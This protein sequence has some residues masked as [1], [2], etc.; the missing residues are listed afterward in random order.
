MDEKGFLFLAKQEVKRQVG[1]EV[2]GVMENLKGELNK[3]LGSFREQK[4]LEKDRNLSEPNVEED[5][6]IEGKSDIDFLTGIWSEENQRRSVKAFILLREKLFKKEIEDLKK[7]NALL[8]A[9]VVA[10]R[11]FKDSIE[12]KLKGLGEKQ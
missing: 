12:L 10:L 1:E 2:N 11:E 5:F 8:E 4:Q 6:V 7:E 9:K 3:A